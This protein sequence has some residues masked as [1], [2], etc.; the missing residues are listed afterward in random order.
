MKNCY[1]IL[2]V[3]V[4]SFTYATAQITCDN[5]LILISDDIEAYTLGDAT[6]QADHWGEWPGATVG[7]I[8]TDERAQSGTKSI[9]IDGNEAGQDALLLLGDQT[10][11]HFIIR[12]HMY[13]PTGN[14]AYFNLQHLMPTASQGYWGFD[15]FF[16]NN[17][18]GTLDLFSE[19]VNFAYP[20]DRWFL[21][22]IFAD[23]DS[24]QARVIVN[25]FT[26]EYWSFS[27]GIT[28][29]G[30][31]FP[32]NGLSAINF[33]PID[34]SHV[35]FI[36]NVNLWQI[37]APEEGQY[38]YTAVSLPGP[39]TYTVPDL[40]CFGGGHD[41][42]GG[43]GAEKGYWFT[44]IPEED[45][46]IG[47]ASCGEGVDT[48]GWIF[49]GDCHDQG[50][51]GV[52]DDQCE[53]LPG[54]SLYATYRE[55]LVTAGTVYYIMW[56][57]AW[58]STGFDF[59]LTFTTDLGAPGNFCQTAIELEGTTLEIPLDGFT[60]NAAVA[61][62][63]IGTTSQGVTPTS[64][65]QSLWYSFTPTADGLVTISSCDGAFSD[66]RVWVYT[67]DCTTFEGLTL[68]AVDDD[69]CGVSSGPSLLDSLAVTAGVTYYIEWDNGWDDLGFFWDFI[70][71]APDVEV[72]F[73]VDM[74][75]VMEFGTVSPN[76]VHI[77]GS[78]QGWDPAATPL[79]DNGDGTW[80]Y[81]TSLPA[82]TE[83]QYKFINGN[84]WGA[85]EMN[86]TAECGVDGGSGSFNRLLEVGGEDV[87]T[88]F[89]CFDFCVT[90]D[91]VAIDETAL[92]AGVSIF[93]NPAEETLHIRFDLA[94]TTENLNVRIFNTL[95]QAVY[96]KYLGRLQTE[97][98]QVDIRPLPA[99]VYLVQVADN[100]TRLTRTIVVN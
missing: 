14:N 54:E 43:D 89:Y 98:L 72:T 77:A 5:P 21:V 16:D 96:E 73:N 62:P 51:I 71:E 82:G 48:R 27:D 59:E 53:L 17:G 75:K 55:A 57:N 68:I 99:G 45:G 58:E 79:T 81:T 64:Y 67:G 93:P 34:D 47:I 95:G 88:P 87:E 20:F 90:C 76:G 78:F 7:G 32:S 52:N 60:G 26:V 83:V 42:G 50:T 19:E 40:T 44:Y 33:Y 31:P 13:I 100:K 18:V 23:I 94:E 86:I 2:I 39:G 1:L 65:A 22:Y 70:F 28:N 49:A 25:D 24:D 38:C 12:F 11:G 69:G 15:M 63:T 41:L 37:P 80:S 97:T 46:V 4:F 92:D 91:L 29:G 10:S 85:D 56:D 35:F 8:V 30:A 74:S 36:D 84:A 61:G 9:K 6:G 66:T 3:F